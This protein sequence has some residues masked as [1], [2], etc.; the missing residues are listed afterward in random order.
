MPPGRANGLA[1]SLQRVGG[2]LELGRKAAQV[3]DDRGVDLADLLG[4]DAEARGVEL[5][6]LGVSEE[7]TEREQ[8]FQRGDRLR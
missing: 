6:D 8:S 4:E 7:G 5:D 2:L 1:L 3:G